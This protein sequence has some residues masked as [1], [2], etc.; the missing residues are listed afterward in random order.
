[1]PVYGT[2][3]FAGLEK[4]PQAGELNLM[5]MV[6]FREL[7]GFLTADRAKEIA[8][9][10]AENQASLK[11]KEVSRENAEAELFG[12]V[13]AVETGQAAPAKPAKPA[14][15][16]PA[17]KTVVA[18]ATPGLRAPQSEGIAGKLAREDLVK[19][20]Y[21]PSQLETGVVLNAAVILDDEK[22]TAATIKAIEEA[23][24]KAGLPLKAITW[25]QASGFIGQLVYTFS[26]VLYIAVLIIFVVALAIIN[27]A[28]VMATLQ[29][30]QEIG[31]LRALGAQRRF[32]LSML[33]LEALVVGV[34]FGALGAGLGAII[35]SV[36]GKVGI[37]A[38]N[39]IS[40]F[41]FSGPRL[42]PFMGT[43][44]LVGALI[45]VFIVSALSSLYP[46]WL[47]MRVS[48]RQAM[49]SE[50]A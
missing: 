34:V 6:S 16:V 32:I 11:V 29:R 13:A 33:V 5:D 41:F 14:R 28:L 7:Y 24:K 49:Q 3:N 22:N 27:N 45:I 1:L 19:R 37:P 9:I 12:T 46:A 30:V 42:H 47:A 31:T 26:A 21:D 38:P 15:A 35:V 10:K 48:P 43:G 23:G 25:Q 40:Y 18:D 8:A 39:D 2:F 50:E 17:P 20:V 36:I 4:S 44:N